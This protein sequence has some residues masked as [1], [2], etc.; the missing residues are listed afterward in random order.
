MPRVLGCEPLTDKDV[1]EMAGASGALG[2]AHAASAVSHAFVAAG[3][4]TSLASLV[5]FAVLPHAR[6]F[7]PKL[8]L[9]P[10]AMPAH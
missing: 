4:L 3:I 9:N 1:A 5:A 10:M 7:V 2:A 8:R 6:E